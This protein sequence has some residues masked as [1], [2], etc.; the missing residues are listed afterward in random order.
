M[1]VRAAKTKPNGLDGK[2]P[3][4]KAVAARVGLTAGTVSAVLN[5]SDASRSV[6]EHTRKRILAAAAALDYRP[7]HLARSL[8][9][10]RTNTIGVIAVEIGDAYGS[11]LISGI[12]KYLRQQNF[13]F[14]TV[15]H[16][17]DKQLLDTYSRLL[18]QRGVEG[19]ISIDTQITEAPLP[20]VAIAGHGHLAGVTNVVLDQ[21]RAAELALRH[22]VELGHRE[23]A[24]MKGSS[25][26][27]D[28]DSRWNA[29]CRVARD[30]G[31]TMHPELIVQLEGFDPTPRLGYPAGKKLLAQK[32]P[33][34]ALFAYNDISALGAVN[35]F[36]EAGLHVPDDVSVVG[37]DDIEIAIHYSPSLTT[38]R[39][40]LLKMGEVAARVLL[41]RLEG[42]SEN[43]AEILIEP[44]LVIRKSTAAVGSR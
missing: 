19:F 17:H 20:T 3:T 33:F 28:A 1:K 42:S 12:E 11:V 30:L 4:L 8:R 36:Q 38:V 16:R 9:V 31:L 44:E 14:L 39:Q 41:E 27:S 18:M 32:K 34:S 10:K 22:L 25:F 7:N 13:F 35:A 29:V 43:P 26:S 24:F 15:A 21:R 2:A 6:P 40:P 23:I 37:L 5:N